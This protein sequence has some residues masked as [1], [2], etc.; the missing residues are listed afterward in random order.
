MTYDAETL[1]RLADDPE[2][3]AQVRAF[4]RTLLA[5]GAVPG[6]RASWV[7]GLTTYGPQQRGSV[8][9]LPRLPLY[10]TLPDQLVPEWAGLAARLEPAEVG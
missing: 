4:A 1:D 2:F 8:I 7:A 5:S 6:N 9:K 10:I 3:V